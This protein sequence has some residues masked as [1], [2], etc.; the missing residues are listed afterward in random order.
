MRRAITYPL[1][2]LGAAASTI[3]V[4]SPALAHGYVSSPPS[5]QSLCATGAVANCGQI[6]F[7]PQ[8]VEGPK[9]LKSCDGGLG[10]FSILNDD[11]RDW[12][13]KPVAGK[14]TFTWVM[15]ARHRTSNWEYFIGG[16]KIAT[17]DGGNAQPDAVVN[18]TVDL[19]AFPGRQKVLAVWNIGDTA[20]AFYSCVDLNVGGGG[21]TVPSTPSNPPPSS[22]PA[23]PPAPPVEEKPVDEK[24]AKGDW[25][26]NVTY[27]TGDKVKFKGQTYECRQGHTS[28]SS[29]EPSIFTLALWLPL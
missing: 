16:K 15:T 19:S 4:A 5:R 25:A 7:E 27:K 8:S 12:P 20:N 1:V 3:V 29:W 9:G 18:H 24:P 13:A 17:V 28:L 26:A 14:A 2:A 22:E 10:Q 6:Q 23:K 11:S 21:G